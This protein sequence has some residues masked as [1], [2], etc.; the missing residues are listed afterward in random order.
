MKERSQSPSS[1]CLYSLVRAMTVTV[2]GEP[3][4]KTVAL[5]PQHPVHLE[6][7]SYSGMEGSKQVVLSN[8]TRDVDG[9]KVR[10]RGAGLRPLLLL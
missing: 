5:P 3:V 6:R 4:A 10:L 2:Q 1:A 9:H 7:M 8:S